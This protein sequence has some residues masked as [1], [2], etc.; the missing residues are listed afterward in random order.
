MLMNMATRPFGRTGLMVSPFAL[1]SMEFGSK[2]SQEEAT[3]LFDLAMDAGINVVDTANIYAGG[4]S[5]QIVGRLIGPSA[6]GW[7]W[8]RSST[9]RPTRMI[10]TQEARR[11]ARSL[12]LARQAFAG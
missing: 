11:V 3:R 10:R 8:R 6:T 4:L 5:E 12:P 1:G 7:C 2:T 9:F